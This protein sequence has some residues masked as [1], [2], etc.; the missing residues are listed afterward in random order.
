MSFLKLK[1]NGIL[2]L[3]KPKGFSSNYILQR[4][5]KIFKSKKAG[6]IGS[7][8]PLA[9]GMLPICFGEA[10]KF[11]MHLLNS[12]KHYRVIAKFG[13]KTSTLDSMGEIISIRP[14]NFSFNTLKKALK[15]FVGKI[16]QI[17]PMYSAI[18]HKGL[19]LYKYARKGIKI[20]RKKRKVFI[21]ELKYIFHDKKILQLEVICSKGTYIRTLIDDVGEYLG[22]GAHIT[23]LRRLKVGSFFT[24]QLVNFNT[25]C[26]YKKNKNKFISNYQLNKLLIPIDSAL[27]IFP[28]INLSI[29]KAYLLKL[30]QKVFS[31][32]YYSGTV[33]I[34][35]GKNK[36]FI[37]IGKNDDLGNLFP[38]RLIS[39]H[40]S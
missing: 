4:V 6:H 38:I 19:E 21:Y 37:G 23:Y 31:S 28:V 36:I 22:C 12:N 25:L 18:K 27:S 17:P 33:R 11:S 26:L 14:V 3:D 24:S 39:T 20:D 5:K 13:E 9:T 30:G 1:K 32:I 29:K 16:F 15:K 35:E 8:D 34:T 10:T 7:L 40:N 2:L